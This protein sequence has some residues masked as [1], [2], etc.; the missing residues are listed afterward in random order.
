MF[1]KNWLK[2]LIPQ[3]IIVA[4][5][6]SAFFFCQNS[7][8]GDFKAIINTGL[9]IVVI[10]LI[11]IGVT[12]AA[13]RSVVANNLANSF[14]AAIFAIN[15]AGVFAG[16]LFVT[17]INFAIVA[18]AA[19][20]FIFTATAAFATSPPVVLISNEYKLSKFWMAVSYLLTMASIFVP[21]F[22]AIRP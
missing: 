13:A 11:A 22:L 9:L 2:I 17:P 4:I 6:L 16:I 3:A 19:A 15:L 12:L 5:T 8:L 1:N 21:I 18:G 14:I 7:G 20:I 10:I